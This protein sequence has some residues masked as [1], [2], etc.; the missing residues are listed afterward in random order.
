MLNG[1]AKTQYSYQH[2]IR[3]KSQKNLKLFSYSQYF[4]SMSS[5]FP[6]FSGIMKYYGS[7]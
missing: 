7:V 5:K 1:V 6:L 4:H 2:L 3:Y